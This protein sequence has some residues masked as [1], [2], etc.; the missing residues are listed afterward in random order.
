MD[1]VCFTERTPTSLSLLQRLCRPLII[2]WRF[3]MVLMEIDRL[4]PGLLSDI[5]VLDGDV[6]GFAWAMANG[7][8]PSRRSRA[9]AV[10][11]MIG[12][13]VWARAFLLHLG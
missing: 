2:A 3:Q 10:A 5:G 8:Q 11:T 6:R 4:S 1:E 12:S 7:E 13:D 9:P